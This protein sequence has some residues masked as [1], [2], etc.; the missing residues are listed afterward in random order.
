MPKNF[1]IKCFCKKNQI[2]FRLW[3]KF[4]P[5][6][7]DELYC[8]ECSEYAARGSLLIFIKQSSDLPL[9]IWAIKFNKDVLRNLDKNF[10]NKK[11]YFID[12]FETKRCVFEPLARKTKYLRY[13]II[14]LKGEGLEEVYA[15][16]VEKTITKDRRKKHKGPKRIKKLN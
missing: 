10:Q 13:F 9:G 7:I 1:L 2:K 16:P 15:R 3:K 6:V 14:G 5:F 8:P 12:L 11:D 4:T